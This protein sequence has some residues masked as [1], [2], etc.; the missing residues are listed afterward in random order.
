MIVEL[1]TFY[2][3]Q[4]NLIN[5]LLCLEHNPNVGAIVMMG[6]RGT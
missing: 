1:L 2:V 4:K 5:W 3:D 6:K